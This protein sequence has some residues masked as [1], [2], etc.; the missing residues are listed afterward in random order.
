MKYLYSERSWFFLL[1]ENKRHSKCFSFYVLREIEFSV[2]LN[3]A[4]LSCTLF[5]GVIELHWMVNPL[6]VN[7][8]LGKLRQLGL[9]N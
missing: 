4:V 8:E 5:Y 6:S 9:S 7:R 1:K 3:I 2:R